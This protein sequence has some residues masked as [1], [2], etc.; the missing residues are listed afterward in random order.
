M[1]AGKRFRLERATLAVKMIDG[2]KTAVTVPAGAIVRVLSAPQDGQELI[3]VL[4]E[5]RELQMFAVDV[6][7]RGTEIKDIETERSL[8][9]KTARS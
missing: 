8:S 9:C 4:W 3:T 6:D 2:K 5:Q 1:L 7:V